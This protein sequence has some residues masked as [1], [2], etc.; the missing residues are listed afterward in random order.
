MCIFANDLQLSYGYPDP[1]Q[2]PGSPAFQLYE[3]RPF[4]YEFDF[5]EGFRIDV[6]VS[7]PVVGDVEVELVVFFS[8]VYLSFCQ[9]PFES[10]GHADAYQLYHYISLFSCLLLHS[11]SGI[12]TARSCQ[13]KAPLS[14]TIW[15]IWSFIWNGC[16]SWTSYTLPR[17]RSILCPL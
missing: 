17:V 9:Q 16:W 11:S 7:C 13:A 6:F 8:F 14:S 5:L 12:T 3:R 15:Y 4:R 2:L 1:F 10:L